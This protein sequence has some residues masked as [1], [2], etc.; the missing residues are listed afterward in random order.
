LAIS[1]PIPPVGEPT[2]WNLGQLY[3]LLDR[4]YRDLKQTWVTLNALSIEDADAKL[5][6]PMFDRLREDA[7]LFA[8]FWPSFR[9]RRK[10]MKG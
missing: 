4:R 8:C 10:G 1:D 3:R 7:E 5:S 2:A 6:A 9:E